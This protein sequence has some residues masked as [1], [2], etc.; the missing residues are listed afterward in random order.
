[1]GFVAGGA[2]GGGEERT[3]GSF[4]G[5]SCFNT[6]SALMAGGYPRFADSSIQNNPETVSSDTPYP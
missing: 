5:G 6:L 3:I 2:L 4:R 1:M